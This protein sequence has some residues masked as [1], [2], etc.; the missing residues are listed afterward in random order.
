MIATLSEPQALP[1]SSPA[2]RNRSIWISSWLLAA[3]AAAVFAWTLLEKHAHFQ[4]YAFDLG[5]MVQTSW[6]TLHGHPFANTLLAW[7]Y[8]ADHFAPSLAIISPLLAIWPH[9]RTFLILQAIAMAVTGIG[10]FT[11]VRTVTA[12]ARIAFALQLAFYFAPT[13]GWVALDEFHPISLALPFLAFATV[14]LWR[15]HP[16]LAAVLAGIALLSTE[17]AASWV[18]PFGL[19]LAAVSQ[20]RRRLWGLGLAAFTLA[21]LGFYF[22]WLVPLLRPAAYLI[23]DPHPDIGVFIYCGR[24]WGAIAHCLF[25]SPQATMRQL[26][27]PNGLNAL[28]A[29]LGPTAF[30]GTFGLSSLAILPRWIIQLL[31]TNPANYTAHY[32]ALLIPPAYLAAGECIGWIRRRSI[33]AAH[34]LARAAAG[35]VLVASGIAFITRSPLPF[36]GTFDTSLLTTTPLQQAEQQALA[37]I[38]RNPA[39]SVTASSSL[40]SHLALRA[41]VYLPWADPVDP[42]FRILAPHDSYPQSEQAYQAEIALWRSEA[43]Y[44]TIYQYD[45]VLVQQHIPSLP[46]ALTL[47]ETF[48]NSVELTGVAIIPEADVL[49]VTLFWHTLQPLPSTM[50]YFVHLAYPNSRIVSQHDGPISPAFQNTV[51]ADVSITTT[52][53]LPVPPADQHEDLHLEIG[54][55]NWNT[56]ARLPLATGGHHLDIAFPEAMPLV[57]ASS[58]DTRRS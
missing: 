20:G 26:T 4:T 16:A 36:G 29:L 41:H 19:V 37:L 13:T 5:L 43:N 57:A 1:A 24:T 42:S 49:E 55:Y 45:G 8:L 3:L 7:N 25:H 54:W 10:I 56:G 38:P 40:L 6:N 11:A 51:P 22:F 33:S 18:G 52:V 17:D 9:A 21:W 30:L 58:S 48:G 27:R 46:P 32:S 35:A 31:S 47:H 44:R 12:D 14:A 34:L 53:T 39:L 15:K 23:S 2:P 50:H 28:E